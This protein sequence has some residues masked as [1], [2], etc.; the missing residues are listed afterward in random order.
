MLPDTETVGLTRYYRYIIAV[1]REESQRISDDGAETWDMAYLWRSGDEGNG[2]NREI[3]RR[4]NR[5]LGTSAARP[6]PL[7]WDLQPGY[8]F[9]SQRLSGRTWILSGANQ[10]R[11]IMARWMMI[12]EGC[13]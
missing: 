13:K 4:D 2:K 3:G 7:S 5:T 10:S 9:D 11:P 12:N 1:G 8:Y 6:S